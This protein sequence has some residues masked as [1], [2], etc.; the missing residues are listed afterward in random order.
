ME[1]LREIP[2]IRC[3]SIRRAWHLNKYSLVFYNYSGI[4]LR[5]LKT[6]FRKVCSILNGSL[7]GNWKRFWN[8]SRHDF[9]IEWDA[10]KTDIL[11]GKVLRGR[12]GTTKFPKS[13]GDF[14]ISCSSQAWTPSGRPRDYQIRV[15]WNTGMSRF[16]TNWFNHFTM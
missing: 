1:Y 11:R 13:D 5:N 2:I 6:L 14:S 16:W 8:L 3:C 7:L 12:S 10:I 15:S 4:L 9:A